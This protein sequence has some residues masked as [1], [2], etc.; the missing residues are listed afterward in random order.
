MKTLALLIAKIA[1]WTVKHIKAII[2]VCLPLGLVGFGVYL[3]H[4]P[5]AFIVVG[6]LIWLDMYVN[7]I[8]QVPTKKT[9][10]GK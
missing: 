7:R 6:M 9:D 3:I 8:P 1:G 2:N 10:D 4:K 5:T